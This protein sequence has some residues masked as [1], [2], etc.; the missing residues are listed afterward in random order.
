M[1][2]KSSKG[3]GKGGGKAQTTSAA[4]TVQIAVVAGGG[5]WMACLAAWLGSAGGAARPPESTVDVCEWGTEYTTVD[6]LLQ[7][8]TPCL[9]RGLEPAK[10]AEVSRQWAP[11]TILRLPAA[12]GDV[13]CRSTEEPSHTRV[14]RYSD[15]NLE[16]PRKSFVNDQLGFSWPREAYDAWE[17]KGKTMHDVLNPSDGQSASFSGDVSAFAG[18]HPSGAVAANA[19]ADALGPSREAHEVVV[20]LASRGL[21]QQLHFDSSSNIFIHMHGVKHVKLAPPHEVLRR[22]H[23]FPRLHP[24]QR[25]S[26]LLWSSEESD[27]DLVGYSTAEGKDTHRPAPVY[28]QSRE[29]LAYLR[30]GD[31]LYIPA[32]W[33]H[34]TFSEL[35]GPTVSMALWYYVGTKE[36]PKETRIQELDREVA[37]AVKAAM[38]GAETPAE[39]WAALRVFAMATAVQVLQVDEAEAVEALAD[40][41]YQRW[42]PQFGGLGIDATCHLPPAV[43][44]DWGKMNDADPKRAARAL[45]PHMRKR[46][47]WHFPGEDQEAVLYYELQNFLDV[48]LLQLQPTGIGKELVSTPSAGVAQTRRKR[49]A[50]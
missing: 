17:F 18:A 6:G 32:L 46:A 4:S 23:L 49:H 35:D 2:R 42:R 28:N 47:S 41:V 5:V 8:P 16:R 14:M 40:W 22:S 26:Q 19:M 33:G 12:R 24:A 43:C 36:S 13:S 7:R 37:A 39:K 38:T 48:L 44:S 15:R 34:Q 3:G 9:V 30:P 1:G 27:R 20:W 11:S 10:H 25:Q 29:Q 50:F 31:V 21:G 45:A